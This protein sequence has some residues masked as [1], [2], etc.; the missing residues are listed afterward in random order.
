MKFAKRLSQEIREEWA[1][2]YISYRKLKRCLKRLKIQRGQKELRVQGPTAADALVE[3]ASP[4][5]DGSSEPRREFRALLDE[6]AAKVA[7]FYVRQW[8]LLHQEFLQLYGH[9]GAPTVFDVIQDA[10]T[11]E[12]REKIKQL[13]I[14]AMRL[15]RYSELNAVGFRKIVKKHDK[16]SGETLSVPFMARLG[17]ERFMHLHEL[18]DL[19]LQLSTAYSQASNGA[20]IDNDADVVRVLLEAG[21]R[22]TQLVLRWRWALLAA[23]VATVLYCVP[24]LHSQ[25]A[26]HRCVSMLAFVTI[27]WVTEAAPFFVTAL[28]V[29]VL[30]VLMRVLRDPSTGELLSAADATKLMLSQVTNH[31]VMLVIGGFAISA[32]FSKHHYELHAASFI[33]RRFGHR[34]RVFLLAV[35]LLAWFLSAWISNVAAPVLVFSVLQPVLHDLP[36]GGGYVKALLLGLAFASNIGGMLTPIASPQNAIALGFLSEYDPADAISFLQFCVIAFPFGVVAVLLLWLFLLVA[37]RPN[38]VVRI[39]EIAFEPQK[40]TWAHYVVLLA[41]L[42]T[43]GLWASLQ[44]TQSVFGDM[45]LVAMFPLLLFLSLGVL[46]KHDFNEF[47]WPLVYLIGGG[48]C[49]GAAISSSGLLALLGDQLRPLLTPLSGWQAFMVLVIAICIVT[50]FV[51]HTVGALILIPVVI[52][53]G[54][55]IGHAKV[56]VLGATLMCSGAMLLPF[57]S[58][59]N[60]LMMLAEDEIGRHYLRVRDFVIYGGAMTLVVL[61]LLASW[62]YLLLWATFA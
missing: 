12:Q 49:L 38:D 25:P 51:S 20:L 52:S 23:V 58:F 4:L 60:T 33:Q 41:T 29:P 40:Y 21:P 53:V 55:E 22:Q 14:S 15:R 61:V 2:D 48:N 47:N 1:Q 10:G 6:D 5:L 62:G 16:V 50:M 26:A 28:A 19:L 17:H 35:M 32:A 34:P 44:Y 9:P 39:S 27:F 13:Y 59:P 30:A 18:D 8:G 43:I 11:Q 45:G 36:E 42:A 3:E 24:I 54:Q 46:S 37:L 7:A 31:T 57:S 56:L